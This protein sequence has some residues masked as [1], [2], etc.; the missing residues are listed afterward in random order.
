MATSSI[1]NNIRITN[2]AQA[3][4]LVNAMEA[5]EKAA[6]ESKR[7]PVQYRELKQGELKGILKG[8]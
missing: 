5:A 6:K 1:F 3:E 2:N 8:K 7:K 4:S